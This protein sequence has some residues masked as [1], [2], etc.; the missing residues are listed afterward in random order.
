MHRLLIAVENEEL[1]LALEEALSSDYTVKTCTDGQQARKLLREFLPELWILELMLP[2]VDGITLLQEAEQ[3]SIR[4]VTL[5]IIPYESPYIMGAMI[6][7]EVA[8]IMKKPCCVDALA[9][10]IQALAATLPQISQPNEQPKIGAAAMLLELGFSPKVDGFGYLV[11]AIPL[12]M[13]DPEQSLTKELYVAL[14]AP[15]QKSSLQVERCIRT[16]IDSAWKRSKAQGWQNYFPTA[17]DGTVPRPTNGNFIS[18]IAAHFAQKA[19]QR[20]A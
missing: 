10:Q 20:G 7:H 1:R 5:A 11:D 15:C 8:Y 3:D 12:Y 2:M 4:P 16:A 19:G 9:G 17:P 14:G 18:H 13:A 6:R